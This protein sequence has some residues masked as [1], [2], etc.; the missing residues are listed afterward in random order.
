M[1]RGTFGIRPEAVE[2]TVTEPPSA[3]TWMTR[4]SPTTIGYSNRMSDSADASYSLPA[5]E[6]VCSSTD[7]GMI[8]TP[9][10]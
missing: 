1:L 4:G 6:S 5:A 9:L 7:I 10:L 3:T 8:S 2:D